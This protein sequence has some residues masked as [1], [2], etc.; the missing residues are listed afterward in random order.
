M[1]FIYQS[2]DF[3]IF[4]YYYQPSS[5]LHGETIFSIA[6]QQAPLSLN[7][8]GVLQYLAKEPDGVMTCFEGIYKL[9][10]AQHLSL[11]QQN[12][13]LSKLKP[14]QC[15]LSILDVLSEAL[16]RICNR[17][18]RCG[19][20]LSGGFDSAL[21]LSIIKDLGIRNV[22]VYTL[23]THLNAYCELELTEKTASH[24]GVELK[25]VEADAEQF[26][27]VLPE[28]VTATETPIYNLHLASKLLLARRMKADG[29][30]CILTGDAADQVFA[31]TP[32]ANYLPLVGAITRSEH[33]AYES[34]FFD[35]RV[36]AV[37]RGQASANKTQL[38]ASGKKRLPTWLCEQKKQARLA[39]DFDLSC[40]WQAND[41]ASLAK[42]LNMTAQWTTSSE[43]MLWISLNLLV[44]RIRGVA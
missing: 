25:V 5:S 10:P 3:A 16:E 26:I 30:D 42:E 2:D 35:P 41:I 43:Q 39:P 29:L 6:Q 28:I 36:I 38:R 18:Q 12:F 7:R 32:S 33:I 21:I 17:H 34:P 22:E 1:T 15:S 9:A 13:T 37:G 31:L 11:T 24:F 4:P 19:L 20:A 14:Q 40:Y 23:A 44:Q 27:A 8:Q